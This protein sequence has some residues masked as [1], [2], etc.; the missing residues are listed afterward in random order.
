MLILDTI[1]TYYIFFDSYYF[2]VV[3]SRKDETE[4]DEEEEIIRCV[5]NIYKDEGIMILC[6]KCLVSP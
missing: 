2:F 6:E 1:K 4:E 5:C 3:E